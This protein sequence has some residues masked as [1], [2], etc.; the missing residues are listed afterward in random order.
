MGIAPSFS[1]STFY[2]IK[3]TLLNNN[4]LLAL[5]IGRHYIRCKEVL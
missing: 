4:I 5:Y 2:T 3:Y 1:L